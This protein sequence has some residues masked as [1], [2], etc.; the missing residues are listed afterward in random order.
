VGAGAAPPGGTRVPRRIQS[1]ELARDP[2][3]TFTWVH[4]EDL[5]DAILAAAGSDTNATVNVIGGDTRFGTYVDA[6]RALLPDSAAPQDATTDRGWR[7]Q[8]AT[9]RLARTFGIEPRRTF[10]EAISEIA[11][12]WSE[13]DLPS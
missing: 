13:G 1:G 8:H 5:V 3:M 9:D 10:E 11:A 4:I 12:W 2:E 6:I 7:G